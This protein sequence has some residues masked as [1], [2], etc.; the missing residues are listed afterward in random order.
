MSVT[1]AAI[2]TA[3]GPAG[4]GIVRLSGSEALHI[5]ARVTHRKRAHFLPRMLRRAIAHDPI[6][7]DGLDDGLIVFF[8][9]PH[10]FTGEDVVE[11]QGHGGAVTLSQVLGAFLAAGA[12]LARP[13]EFSERAF[14]N[15]KLDLAQ[16]EALADLIS[17]RSVAAQRAARRLI[18]GNTLARSPHDCHRPSRSARAAGGNH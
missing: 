8:P 17:A 10:S 12:R 7:G 5:A 4:V 2:A 16:A 11:F 3:A 18:G 1:I 14:H 15:G 9:A 13:G 6:T